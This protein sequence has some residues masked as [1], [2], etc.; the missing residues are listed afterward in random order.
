MRLCMELTVNITKGL[1]SLAVLSG[2]SLIDV[3]AKLPNM[4][5]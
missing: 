1:E 3:Y 5:C 4:D 2:V